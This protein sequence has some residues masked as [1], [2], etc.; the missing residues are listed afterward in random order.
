MEAAFIAA[1]SIRAHIAGVANTGISPEPI[2]SAVL[3]SFTI[4]Y[5]V[6]VLIIVL[7]I[8]YILFYLLFS[9]SIL[10]PPFFTWLCY[11]I[12][13][14]FFVK[15]VDKKVNYYVGEEYCENPK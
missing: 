4:V 6:Y 10:L 11:L 9:E 15:W 5:E 3:F 13:S 8:D 7:L 12:Y 14:L 2:L 1:F